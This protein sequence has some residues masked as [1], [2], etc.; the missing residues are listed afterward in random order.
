M[1][2]WVKL[3]RIQSEHIASGMGRKAGPETKV[4]DQTI[5]L[6]VLKTI[7]ETHSLSR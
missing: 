3:R 2:S 6:R 4:D 7:D 1:S 5:R